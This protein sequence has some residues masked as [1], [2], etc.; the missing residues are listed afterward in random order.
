[1]FDEYY[2]T[3]W[4]DDA[5][6]GAIRAYTVFARQS[7]PAKQAER[8]RE[9]ISNYDRLLQ[10]FPDSPLLKEAETAY[11]EALGML[12]SIVGEQESQS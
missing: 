1:M 8:L 10:I 9:A 2:D 6:L 11:T 5:L 12:R 4:A 3:T 7:V